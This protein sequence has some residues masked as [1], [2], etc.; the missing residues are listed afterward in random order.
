MYP[1]SLAICWS[2]SP[3]PVNSFLLSSMRTLTIKSTSFSPKASL[4]RR[5][6]Y[7]PFSPKRSHR[8]VRDRSGLAYSVSMYALTSFIR[9]RWLRLSR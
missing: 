9:A 8:W 6:R 2:D 7:L 1:T 5:L 3:V 4:K